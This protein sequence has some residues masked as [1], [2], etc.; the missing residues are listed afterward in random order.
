MNEEIRR[1]DA[2]SR[3]EMVLD[4]QV[5]SFAE[6]YDD[7]QRVVFPHTVTRPEF[8]DNG[9]AERVVRMALDD[10]RAAGRTVVANC[11]FVAQFI[12]DNPDYHDLLAA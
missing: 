2:A 5:V 12:R 6:F 3:Y 8:Q 10:A 11:W 9:Y 4:G 1:N 7:G